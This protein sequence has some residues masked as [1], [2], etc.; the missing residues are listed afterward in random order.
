[1]FFWPWE[2]KISSRDCFFI[3]KSDEVLK[4]NQQRK[5]TK[6]YLG[7]LEKNWLDDRAANI[8]TG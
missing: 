7:V 2:V 6:G 3:P 5:T 8:Q 4:Q 1:V